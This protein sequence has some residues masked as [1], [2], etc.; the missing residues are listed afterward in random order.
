MNSRVEELLDLIDIDSDE[1]REAEFAE[2]QEILN[3]MVGKKIAAAE[4]GETRITVTTE[5]GNRYFFYGFLSGS[6]A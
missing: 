1:L 2:A 6:N 3:T 4:M 5:D